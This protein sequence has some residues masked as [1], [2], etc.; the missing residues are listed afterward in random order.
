MKAR[1]PARSN[2]IEFGTPGTVIGGP[3]FG[4]VVLTSTGSSEMVVP[5]GGENELPAYAT[6]V[7]GL[8]PFTKML[9]KLL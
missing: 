7:S 6:V 1:T 8:L 9:N 3:G 2:T 4:G 5:R